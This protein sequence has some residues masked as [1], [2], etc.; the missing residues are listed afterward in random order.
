MLSGFRVL[1][2]LVTLRLNSNS[3]T[4]VDGIV[5]SALPA[6]STLSLSGNALTGIPQNFLL[7]SSVVVLELRGNLIARLG[8][9]SVYV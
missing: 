9:A 3:L 4:E 1:C 7:D 6:L 2:S 5:P 8:K